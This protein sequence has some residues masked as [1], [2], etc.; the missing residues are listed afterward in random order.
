MSRSDL[1]DLTMRLVV[2][3]LCALLAE[4]ASAS[5]VMGC[6][7]GLAMLFV[8]ELHAGLFDEVFE[9]VFGSGE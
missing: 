3:P 7:A 9:G 6:V 5:V 8:A 4:S 1:I 2:A